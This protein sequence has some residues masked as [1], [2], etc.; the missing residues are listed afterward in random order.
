VTW[1][2][3]TPDWVCCE[4]YEKPRKGMKNETGALGFR[5]QN[6]RPTD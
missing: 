2:R 4:S 3:S 6:S 1:V 5:G